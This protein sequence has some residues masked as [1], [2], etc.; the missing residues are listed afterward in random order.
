VGV[1]GQSDL[2]KKG[3]NGEK[4][5]GKGQGEGK[6]KGSEEEDSASA[7][8]AETGDEGL[9]GAGTVGVG[10]GMGG[11]APLSQ[12]LLCLA[13][14]LHS[15]EACTPQQSLRT[16]SARFMEARLSVLGL[17]A[18]QL[19]WGFTVRRVKMPLFPREYW[20]LKEIE[21]RRLKDGP[22]TRQ[23]CIHTYIHIHIYIHIYKHTHTYTHTQTHLTT[24]TT[25]PPHT[26]V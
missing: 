11:R 23:V 6:S 26:G 1:G 19:R 16:P 22:S 21:A 10:V 18:P 8:A 2:K 13:V 7:S 14:Q 24:H 5:E 12:S 17:G 15:I 20:D 25:I 4:G 9:A 3:K